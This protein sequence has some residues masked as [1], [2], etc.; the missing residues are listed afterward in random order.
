M[1][2]NWL[3]LSA[4][5]LLCFSVMAIFITHA[6]KQGITVPCVM[7]IISLVWL[8]SFGYLTFLTGTGKIT[9]P[10]FLILIAAAALSVIGNWAQFKAASLAD[11]AGY[12]FAIIGCQS[13][14]IAILAVF[15]LESK[16]GIQQILGM[17]LCICGIITLALA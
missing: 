3:V 4:I 8:F 10:L 11:N 5:A 1:T 16:I 6:V 17:G 9:Y 14:L 7:L 2:N 13:A 15:F 12:A